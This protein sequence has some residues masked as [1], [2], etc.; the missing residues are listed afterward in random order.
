MATKFFFTSLIIGGVSLGLSLHVWATEK[1][2]DHEKLSARKPS[3]PVIAKKRQTESSKIIQVSEDKPNTKS[4]SEKAPLYRPPSRGAPGGR[5][6]GGTRVPSEGLPLLY[7]LVP[8]HIGLTGESQ[9]VLVWY[10]SK[11]TS[12]P[13]EFTV[14]DEDGVAPLIERPL[15]SPA[16]PGI[17]IIQSAQYGVELK[18]GKTYQW[19]VS[20]V[21]DPDRRSRDIVAGGRIEVSGVSP[22]ISKEVQV[23]DPVTA[24]TL[25]AQSGFWYDAIG[26]ISTNI[27]AH[28]SDRTMRQLRASLLNEVD[29]DTVAQVDRQQGL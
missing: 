2:A 22:S 1:P 10:L 13:L 12:H 3:I 4:S 14:I 15:S 23:A 25:M 26:I 27:Q 8:D 11:T 19:F 7:A 17:N 6:G 16:V 24:A 28:P 18:K 9:P 5:V 21:S 29:L 20:L